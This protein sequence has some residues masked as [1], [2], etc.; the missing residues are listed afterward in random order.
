MRCPPQCWLVPF[1]GASTSFSL[2]LARPLLALLHSLA[3]RSSGFAA[4]TRPVCPS[5][6]RHPHTAPSSL[7]P[8]HSASSSLARPPRFRFCELLNSKLADPANADKKI[9]YYSSTHAHKRTNSAYLLSVYTMLFM[10]QTPEEAFR[11]FEDA[12]PPFPPFHDASPCVCT[13]N[14]TILDCLRGIRK[15]LDCGFF[16]LDNFDIEEYEHFEK[17]ENGDLNWIANGKV[18]GEER[19]EREREREHWARG[20]TGGRRCSGREYE[21]FAAVCC[22][23]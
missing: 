13:Y 8:P 9:V 20:C 12:Y 17:V 14:L 23:V 16:D 11:P 10:G 1:V 15:A 22:V 6:L 2:S 4:I 19:E 3:T 7:R 5:S 21:L 18:Q